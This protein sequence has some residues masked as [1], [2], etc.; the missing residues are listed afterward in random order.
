MAYLKRWISIELSES[1]SCWYERERRNKCIHAFCTFFMNYC[2]FSSS[3][4]FKF[5][6]SSLL[7]IFHCSKIIELIDTLF[8]VL[9]KKGNQLTFLHLYHH[10]TIV[11]A[12]W[13]GVKFVPG[14]SCMSWTVVCTY[15]H[16]YSLSF[17][18]KILSCVLAAVI[19]MVNSWIHVFMYFYYEMMVLRV[20]TFRN[21][22]KFVTILQIVS[23]YNAPTNSS[24]RMSSN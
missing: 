17:Q 23:D 15:V 19:A 18:T 1:R 21:Y 2:M 13:I 20:K 7:W 6:I 22:K 4:I 16:I 8:L 3:C 10:S 14:G 11:V 12:T 5:Q 24:M 9:K